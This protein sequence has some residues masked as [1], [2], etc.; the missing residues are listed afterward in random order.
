M[1][2]V[3]RGVRR[4]GVKIMSGLTGGNHSDLNMLISEIKDVRSG[5]KTFMT[6]QN[7]MAQHLLKWGANEN[8]AIQDVSSQL[9][10]INTTWTEVQR[11]FNENL[12]EIKQTFELILEGEKHIDVAKNQLAV[13]EHREAKLKKE[14]KKV[15]KR[16]TM[17]EL[18][19]LED[20]LGQAER[21]K[22]LAHLELTERVDESEAIKMIRLKQGLLQLAEAYVEMG[23]KCTILHEAA[24]DIVHQLPDVSGLHGHVRG[25]KYTGAGA[26]KYS[27]FQAK[28]KVG[29][30]CR[31]VNQISS[32]ESLALPHPSEPPPPYSPPDQEF[33]QKMASSRHHSPSLQQLQEQLNEED[34]WLNTTTF[35]Q[36]PNSPEGLAWCLNDFN[37]PHTPTTDEKRDSPTI[38]T[39]LLEFLTSTPPGKL[40]TINN[41]NHNGGNGGG[42]TLNNR[43]QS[44]LKLRHSEQ[45]I[46]AQQHNHNL[47]PPKQLEHQQ[48]QDHIEHNHSLPDDYDSDLDLVASFPPTTLAAA[49]NHGQLSLSDASLNG[50][51][52]LCYILATAPGS[53][54]SNR[55]PTSSI[56]AVAT[57][58]SRHSP[59][60]DSQVFPPPC[61]DSL[62]R[63]SSSAAAVAA[64]A[65]AAAPNTP[66]PSAIDSSQTDRIVDV[67]PLAACPV[68]EIASIR[69][70]PPSTLSPPQPAV[71][72]SAQTDENFDALGELL[73]GA[74]G[75]VST[76]PLNLDDEQIPGTPD[77]L[78][79]CCYPPVYVDDLE[80]HVGWDTDYDDGLIA[81][82]GA[83]KID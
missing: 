82:R 71:S 39:N 74:S 66:P 45:Q 31:P 72:Q 14:L 4:G 67:K 35:P 2:R 20:R 41:N 55:P 78:P 28:E 77:S 7:S 13:C 3:S 22:Y 27:V 44:M 16:A 11:D 53:A 40:S 76:S 75:A 83:A 1:D 59:I 62:P 61:Y 37:H 34:L 32:P 25:M 26:T 42:T 38:P 48:Y 24:R 43:Q 10:E 52:Q 15:A 5:G 29:Q 47:S 50:R 54:S 12:R 64:A 21:A 56:L 51:P 36:G 8:R 58:T 65:A 69:A 18:D 30:Y 73:P 23:T 57:P 68:E 9:C 49:I 19:Q 79:L 17:D 60:Q 63:S 6:A 70:E 33:L 80:D 46:L 81:T